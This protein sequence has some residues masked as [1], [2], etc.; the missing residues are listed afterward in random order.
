MGVV[1]TVEGIDDGQENKVQSRQGDQE[2]KLNQKEKEKGYQNGSRSRAHYCKVPLCLMICQ[3][4]QLH[5]TVG[6]G[7]FWGHWIGNVSML[8][9]STGYISLLCWKCLGSPHI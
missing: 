1:L 4:V 3:I 2:R 8:M 6:L 5:F 9:P 7:T